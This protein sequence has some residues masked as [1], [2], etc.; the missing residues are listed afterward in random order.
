MKNP[1]NTLNRTTPAQTSR[2]SSVKGYH[3]EEEK[4]FIKEWI[5]FVCLL[6]EAKSYTWKYPMKKKDWKLRHSANRIVQSFRIF[7]EWILHQ[8][9][10]LIHSLLFN[11]IKT[12]SM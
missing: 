11:H 3:N 6:M 5:Y 12:N 4:Y 7:T 2:I 9:S 8:Q 10:K 1:I